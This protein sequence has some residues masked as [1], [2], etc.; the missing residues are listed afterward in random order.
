MRRMQRK[1]IPRNKR[2]K[3]LHAP[4]RV[5]GLYPSVHEDRTPIFQDHTILLHEMHF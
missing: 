3:T 4:I 2:I 5:Y 1:I